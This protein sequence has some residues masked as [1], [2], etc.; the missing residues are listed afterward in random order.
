MTEHCHCHIQNIFT[1][2]YKTF[3]FSYTKHFHCHIQNIFTFIYRTF[4][5]SCIYTES[6]RLDGVFL[7]IYIYIYICIYLLVHIYIYT[8][9]HTHTHTHTPIYTYREQPPGRHFLVP[10][11][12]EEGRAGAFWQD[13]QSP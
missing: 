3:S 4:S 1:F 2:I 9:T 13:S 8:H 7:C 5:L 10:W 12:P 11:Q 6:S